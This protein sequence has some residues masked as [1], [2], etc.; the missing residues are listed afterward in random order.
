M[1]TAQ[2][3]IVDLRDRLSKRELPLED[4]SLLPQLREERQ[5]AVA[6][7]VTLGFAKAAVEKAVDSLLAASPGAATEEIIK[8][9]LRM[10]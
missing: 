8:Q 3:I 9:A 5:E 10:L 1:K 4:G 7:L 2:R 6:A